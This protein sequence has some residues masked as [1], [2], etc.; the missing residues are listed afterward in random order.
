MN[1]FAAEAMLAAMVMVASCLAG[2]TRY[3]AWDLLA[4]LGG[5]AEGTGDVLDSLYVRYTFDDSGSPGTAIVI[6]A[7]FRGRILSTKRYN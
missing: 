1:R 2:C 7:E 5:G 3:G 6:M 4:L